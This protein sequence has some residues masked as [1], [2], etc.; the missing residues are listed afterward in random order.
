MSKLFTTVGAISMLIFYNLLI[1]PAIFP[2][3]Q[4]GEINIPKI[5]GAGVAGALGVGI[6][7]ATKFIFKKF[8]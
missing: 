1:A 5:I 2:S 4:V 6:G 8:K 7:H 3:H